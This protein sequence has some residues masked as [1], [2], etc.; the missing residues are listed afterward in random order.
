MRTRAP[1]GAAHVCTRTV[2]LPV[3]VRGGTTLEVVPPW[4]RKGGGEVRT[5][6]R[7]EPVGARVHMHFFL[8]YV[9]K[10][11]LFLSCPVT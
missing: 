8:W 11:G 5:Q 3:C 10:D 4:T 1:A 7:A 9:F 6:T 2:R